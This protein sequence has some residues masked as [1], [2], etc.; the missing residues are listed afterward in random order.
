MPTNL[1]DHMDMAEVWQP[2]TIAGHAK[3][4]WELRQLISELSGEERNLT[5]ILR[6]Y[7]EKTGEP[8]EV[9]GVP[10]L[11]VV[12]RSAGIAYDSHAIREMCE[13]RPEEW[14]RIVELGAVSLSTT[15]LREAI[16]H[17]QLVGMPLGGIEKRA[18]ALV[19]DREDR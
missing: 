3:R 9:E 6:E 18:R 10:T 11:R 17:D 14:R 13:K 7:I 1:S 8:V 12:E 4:L 16:K 2:G 19:F 15:M 5:T